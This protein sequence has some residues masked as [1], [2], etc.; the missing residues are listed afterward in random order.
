MDLMVERLAGA[1][2]VHGA[3]RKGEPLLGHCDALRRIDRHWDLV[4]DAVENE[5]GGE[6]LAFDADHLPTGRLVVG[7]LQIGAH[8]RL[9]ADLEAGYAPRRQ[10]GSHALAV[11]AD[12]QEHFGRGEDDLTILEGHGAASY[13][14]AAIFAAIR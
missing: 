3:D 7:D 13:V 14:P 11:L 8:G 4:I 10:G 2:G 9:A 1:R 5:C 6:R 12:A